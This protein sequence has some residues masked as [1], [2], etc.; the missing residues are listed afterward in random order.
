MLKAN[1]LLRCGSFIYFISEFLFST[2]SLS[3]VI[4]NGEI[5]S[6]GVLVC[7]YVLLFSVN[8]SSRLTT[9]AF[10]KETSTSTIIL[11]S[12]LMSIMNFFTSMANLMWQMN[13]NMKFQHPNNSSFPYSNSVHERR[14]YILWIITFFGYCLLDAIV[15]TSVDVP[16]FATIVLIIS[17]VAMLL[18]FTSIVN[19]NRYPF[20]MGHKIMYLPRYKYVTHSKYYIST[21]D[22]RCLF[23]QFHS[24]SQMFGSQ[25]E[26]L[27]CII[28]CKLGFEI[29]ETYPL[30]FGFCSI[31]QMYFLFVLNI[32]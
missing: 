14:F 26:F 9:N 1:F 3:I 17:G 16:L 23:R 24:C 13:E 5:W 7:M 32:L 10:L 27:L 6:V 12:F 2:F 11:G 29:L 20:F 8:V 15:M 19:I 28:F 21:T 30:I 18:S 25:H 4:I 31:L 22:M